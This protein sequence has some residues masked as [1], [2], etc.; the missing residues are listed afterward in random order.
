MG[1]VRRYAGVD[2]MLKRY[3][4]LRLQLG[5]PRTA[6]PDPHRQH[7]GQPSR[8]AGLHLIIEVADIA[9]CIKGAR[10]TGLEKLVLHQ[11][12]RDRHR[13]CDRCRRTFEADTPMCPQCLATRAAGWTYEPYPTARVLLEELNSNGRRALTYYMIVGA[14]ERAYSRIERTMRRRRMLH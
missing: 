13:Y 10:L 9:R 2:E 12:T 1:D 5:V 8:D 14:R 11:L 7:D 4:E 6:W 3:M